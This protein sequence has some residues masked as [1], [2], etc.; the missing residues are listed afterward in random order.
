MTQLYDTAE[1]I[2]E[3]LGNG[4]EG[5]N[6]LARDRQFAGYDRKERMLSWVVLGRFGL[7]SCGNFS[8]IVD[9][10]PADV[11][12]KGAVP[13]VMTM[14]E[15]NAYSESFTMAIGQGVPPADKVCSHCHHGWELRNCHDNVGSR[16]EEVISLAPYVGMT[17]ATFE[18][19]VPQTA[20]EVVRWRRDHG[21]RNDRLIDL[22]PDPKY[23]T[24][25]INE[26][27]WYDGSVPA[28]YVIQAGDEA[29]I[30]K[31]S[32]MHAKCKEMADFNHYFK[33]FGE[34][35]F[36]AGYRNVELIPIPNQYPDKNGPWFRVTTAF[37]TI[38]IG[39]R[40]RVI[41]IDWSEAKLAIRPD[42]SK[43][44]VTKEESF[45]HAWGYEAAIEYLRV[46]RAA[47]AGE[48][49]APKTR[50]TAA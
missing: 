28:D 35:F 46:L 2:A 15:A 26:L 1:G 48:H 12:R 22:T 23:T 25:K 9:G 16:S 17:A 33:K 27:G 10:A 7:D 29:L 5:L 39:W 47:A 8:T 11:Y 20:T 14:D 36:E 18:A 30:Y 24:L 42:F 6:W 37:G 19:K 38:T 3:Y 45:I 31:F 34:L 49:H 50:E 43:E 32:W 21:I 44:D 13:R 41:N 40:R 4:L